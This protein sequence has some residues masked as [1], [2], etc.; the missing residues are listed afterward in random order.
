MRG[1]RILTGNV[2]IF[3]FH[4]CFAPCKSNL[5]KKL[6]F[7]GNYFI[8]LREKSVS[9]TIDINKIKFKKHSGKSI[10]QLQ[11]L[12]VPEGCCFLSKGKKRLSLDNQMVQ[13]R[14]ELHLIQC[15][16]GKSPKIICSPE[17]VGISPISL[18]L[19]SGWGS[20]RS[21]RSS[22]PSATELV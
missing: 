5:L 2:S 22:L 10:M 18:F 3:S 21:S 11:I 1:L 13:K 14:T 19:G 8:T 15:Q 7:K 20:L 9:F 12:P 6:T 16:I 4:Q 17:V